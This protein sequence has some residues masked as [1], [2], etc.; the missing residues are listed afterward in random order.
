MVLD[1]AMA[2]KRSADFMADYTETRASE[3]RDHDR[4]RDTVLDD[5]MDDVFSHAYRDGPCGAGR[6]DSSVFSFSLPWQKRIVNGQVV[7]E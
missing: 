1:K 6:R 3:E 5:M 2:K 7:E 4:M